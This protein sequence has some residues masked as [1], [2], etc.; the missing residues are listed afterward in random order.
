M[1][2]IDFEEFRRLMMK[3]T[4]RTSNAFYVLLLLNESNLRQTFFRMFLKLFSRCRGRRSLSEVLTF[5]D[6]RTNKHEKK[7]SGETSAQIKLNTVGWISSH[8]GL[9]LKFFSESMLI[10]EIFFDDGT[11]IRSFSILESTL[12]VFI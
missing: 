11:I 1:N 10:S 7:M 6:K 8:S 12:A 4:R 2:I 5:T 3:T 9:F